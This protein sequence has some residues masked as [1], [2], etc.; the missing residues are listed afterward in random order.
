MAAPFPPPDPIVHFV[1]DLTERQGT[2][3]AAETLG[4]SRT[5][6]ARLCGRLPVATGTVALIERQMGGR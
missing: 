4:I 3:R 1:K 6:I 5:T 2:V